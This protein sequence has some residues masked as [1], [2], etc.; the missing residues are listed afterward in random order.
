MSRTTPTRLRSQARARIR[1]GLA[2]V[3]AILIGLMLSTVA[4]GAAPVPGEASLSAANGYARLVLKF[5][6]DV[7]ADV[8]TAGSILLIRFDRP[9]NVLIDRW[10]DAAPDY[11]SSARGDPDGSALRLSLSRKVRVNTM[12]AGERVFIDLLPDS[13]TGPPPPLPAEVVRELAERARV[14]ERALRLQRAEAESKK[15]PPIRVRALVQPT[16]VRFVFEIPDGVGISSVLND[17]KLSLFFTAPLSFDLA[18]A[19]IVAP[20]NVAAIN[21]RID[22]SKTVVEI[23]M[24]GEVDVHAFREE[25]NYNIDVAYAQPDKKVAAVSSDTLPGAKAAAAEKAN[26]DKSNGE[27]P[28]PAAQPEIVQP[29]SETIAKEMKAEAKPAPAI[30]APATEPAQPAAAATPAPAVKAETAKEAPK[31]AAKEAVKS[32]APQT[33]AAKP[34][35]PKMEAVQAEMTKPEAVKPEAAKSEP[36]KPEPAKAAEKSAEKPADA[37]T[38][39]ALRDSEGLRLTFGFGQ[40]TPA[41]LFRRGDTVW[42]VFDSTKPVDVE[43]IRAKGGAIIGEVNRMPLDKGQAIR[44]RLNRPQMHSLGSDDGGRSWT[45][46]FA[47]KGQTNQQPLMVMRNVTDPA[48]ANV[49][50]PLANPGAGLLH[51]LTDPDAGDTLLVVTAP[52]P[53]RGFIKRQDFVDLSLLDSI[54]GI[55]VRPNSEDIAVEIAPDKVILGRPGGLTLSSIGFSPE[56]A[57]AAVRPMFDVDEWQQNQTLPFVPREDMLIKAAASAEPERRAQ[58]RLALARFYMARAM[59]P[60]ARGVTNLMISDS[61]PRT[62]ETAMLMIHAVASI[63]MG[64]P[65]QGLKDLGNA[66]IGNNFDSQMWKGL[67][68]AR[69]GKFADAREKLKNVEFAIAS[70]PLDLQRVVIADAMKSALEIKDFA[71]AAKRRAELDVIG[72]PPDMKPDVA[73]LRGRLGEAMAQEKDALDEYRLAINSDDRPAA[74]EAKLFEIKLLQKRGEIKPADA[75][76]DL[77]TL[78]AIWRGDAVE[79]QTLQMMSQLYEEAGRYADSLEAARLATRLMPNSD[80]ARQAQDA[81]SRLFSQLFLNG[82]AD[83]LP[84]VDALSIFYG[85]RELTPI[86]RRG[87]EMIR[88]LADRLVGIDLL[89]QAAELLQYQVDH[90]LEGAARAQVAARLAM[91]YLTNRKPDRA[92]EALRT[93]RI[94]DLSGE[95]RQQRLLLEARAN[96]DIGR[97]D[98]G[99]DIISNIGGREAIR[100]RSDIYW[101]SRRW[102]EASEQIEL[103]YGDRWR[104]FRPLNP[105]ERGDILRAVVGYALAD[106]AIG[107]SRFREKYAPLMTG[108]ADKIA[109]DVA[110]KPASG[111]SAEFAQIAKM[112]ASV[113]TLD[114]FLRDMRARFPDATGKGPDAG[115]DA[116]KDAGKAPSEATGTLPRIQGVKQAIAG[117]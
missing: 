117:R 33:E 44:L 56:R 11:I 12:T 93:T 111:S 2:L 77:E 95:L 45:L 40:V 78:Q 96:S 85:F 3:S 34:E 58:A 59:Y 53:I 50:V 57:P 35:A 18:D 10:V 1:A 4:A 104:D 27:K 32:E 64:R 71:G 82:K 16:F 105:A 75:L 73:V 63:L 39:E 74:A 51:R 84:P 69:Q 43:P 66:S 8:V 113:D 30:A 41:A 29:T 94:A 112:A 90:R 89:D 55:A 109:F 101:A 76:K 110:S 92:I 60:E 36:A 25:K 54:H 91:V 99:L 46:S 31:E 65:D 114:G 70:L 20:P 80:M 49:V 22:G 97:Y 100:L 52:P 62:D 19:K 13:W 21:Q 14:A 116:A 86:G 83:E 42:M 15:R 28:K 9:A 81:A 87:D 107:L 68:Y 72:V 79:V 108:E 48:L 24:I 88:K 23:G 7:G 26:G 106:D 47:D 5:S 38:L 98:L 6:E 102:R 67:A 37:A 17:Q 103:Y 115:K 61:D